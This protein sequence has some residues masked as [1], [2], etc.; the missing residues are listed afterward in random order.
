MYNPFD[1]NDPNTNESTPTETNETESTHTEYHYTNE[2]LRS[3]TEPE[4]APGA[5]SK[6]QEPYTAPS[7]GTTASQSGPYGTQQ[8]GQTPYPTQTGW[9]YGASQ[10]QQAQQ[11]PPQ[12]QAAY[13]WNGAAQQGAP[14]YTPAQP[15]PKKHRDGKKAKK[16]GLR[17]V[18]AV[19]CCA[20]VSF[21]SVGIFAAM[22]QTGLI[23]VESTGSSDTAAFTLYKLEDSSQDSETVV[24]SSALTRQ[25]AAQKMIPSV[26]CIQNY[27][28]S[29]QGFIFGYSNGEDS[30]SG[31]LAGEGSGIIISEDG[32]IVTNQHVIDGATN[33]QVVTSDGMT[34]EA[35]VVGEDTQTDLAVIKIDATGLTAAEFDSSSDLQVGDEVMAVGNPGGMQLNSTVTFGYVSALNRPVTNSDTG[36]TVN[37]IQTDAAINPG[38]SGGALVNMKGQVVGINSAK[39]V[40]DGYEGLGFAIPIDDAQ[41]IISDLTAYGYVRDR[42]A[43]GI[44][45]QYIDS[46]T[47]RFNG[48][49][50]GMYVAQITS[51]NVSDAGIQEGDVIMQIDGKDVTSTESITAVVTSKKP[52]DTVTLQVG[53]PSTGEILTMDVTLTQVTGN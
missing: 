27:Q 12:N 15:K 40:A 39:I 28:I 50:T 53:R 8:T 13:T 47:A 35:T 34:Y 26:V 38:N 20:V 19:L 42:A 41:P 44:S 36:Y 5:E 7:Y 46:I 37:C 33:L 21:A 22:I 9:Q 2:S 14:Y 10:G 18:A 11:V 49:P 31:S 16:I 51:S 30:S 25:E 23:N 24:N 1:H 52:G 29:Q 6:P 4:T 17:V 3:H 45:G 48:L 32:Y 43:L